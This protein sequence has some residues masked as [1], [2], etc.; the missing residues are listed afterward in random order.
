MADDNRKEHNS[1]NMISRVFKLT[2]ALLYCCCIVSSLSVFQ[3]Y[4][5][6]FFYTNFFI[7]KDLINILS[8]L[9]LASKSKMVFHV[10]CGGDA[11]WAWVFC[12]ECVFIFLF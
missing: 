1:E 12:F 7:N 4:R 2:C 5:M 6:T 8:D 11:V 10:V 3:V 9:F